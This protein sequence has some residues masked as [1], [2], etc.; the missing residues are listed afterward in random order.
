MRCVF[1][2]VCHANPIHCSFVCYILGTEQK[3]RKYS[4]KEEER[5]E[6]V[7]KSLEL[8]VKL[9]MERKPN[10]AEAPSDSEGDELEELKVLLANLQLE[11]DEDE[12]LLIEKKTRFLLKTKEYQ[13]RK[14]LLE[15]Q[16]AKARK[17]EE[18]I[19]ERR[20]DSSQGGISVI[21]AE[22]SLLKSSIA[23]QALKIAVFKQ[24]KEDERKNVE[25][26]VGELSQVKIQLLDQEEKLREHPCNEENPGPIIAREKIKLQKLLD[27]LEG[28]SKIPCL[29]TA[30]RIAQ[31]EVV[32]GSS[33][34]AEIK[35]PLNN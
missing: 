13:T 15:F 35:P 7:S 34:K 1:R 21:N 6:I 32:A 14:T 22:V 8:N 16:S 31:A 3:Q 18:K 12:R 25:T 19:E 30:K 20:G 24:Q 26:L 17:Q 9:N 2:A 29:T 4:S 27:E 33:P 5:K 23:K 10:D 28:Y 11:I